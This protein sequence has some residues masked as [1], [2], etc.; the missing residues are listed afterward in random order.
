MG[1]FCEDTEWVTIY[2]YT[3]PANYS[4]KGFK[5]ICKR[6]LCTNNK[7]M[8]KKY[9]PD[10]GRS[11]ESTLSHAHC[12]MF[13]GLLFCLPW[14]TLG[15]SYA[16]RV[17]VTPGQSCI[18]VANTGPPFDDSLGLVHEMTW[19]I[20]ASQKVLLCSFCFLLCFLCK[21]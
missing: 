7:S 9:I 16:C 20:W 12:N 13:L 3:P 8:R 18:L 10:I 4:F 14:H 1:D 21:C 2:E 15:V 11:G 17:K 6:I 5:T 19:N